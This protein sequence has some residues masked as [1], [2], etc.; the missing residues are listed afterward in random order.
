MQVRG[1]RTAE[2]R[3]PNQVRGRAE[4]QIPFRNDRKKG[5]SKS[6]FQYSREA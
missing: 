6:G 2:R 5:K 1:L 4:K 3:E